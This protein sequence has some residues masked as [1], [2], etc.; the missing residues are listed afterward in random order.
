MV[1]WAVCPGEEAISAFAAGRLAREERDAFESHLD[2]CSA[3]TELVAVLAK[4]AAPAH[5]TEVPATARAS[6]VEI[7]ADDALLAG[8]LG[9][10]L[11]LS[12]LGAGGMG[13]V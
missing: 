10:Y 6:L 12:R 3:C 7:T 5:A 13:V 1:A 9:R 11:L 2:T 4:L 8:Q